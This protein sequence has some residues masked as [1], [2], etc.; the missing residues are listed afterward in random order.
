MTNHLQCPKCATEI[1]WQTKMIRS[2]IR[3]LDCGARVSPSKPHAATLFATWF[4]VLYFFGITVG[5]FSG[6]LL[7]YLTAIALLLA[8]YVLYV[9]LVVRPESS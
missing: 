3:C 1:P 7:L 4:F 6:N 9:P 8:H 2:R 5:G